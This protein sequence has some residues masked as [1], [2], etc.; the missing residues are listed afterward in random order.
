[1]SRWMDG[2]LAMLNIFQLSLCIIS[3]RYT[4]FP[5][6]SWQFKNGNRRGLSINCPLKPIYRRFS[7]AMIFL[8]RGDAFA[9]PGISP[10]H[11]SNQ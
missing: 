6:P 3:Q 10:A 7:N 11:G 5:R 8:L 4:R 1:M 2:Q 9:N